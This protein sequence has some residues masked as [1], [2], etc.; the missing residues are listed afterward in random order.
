[1]KA[2]A[3]QSKSSWTTSSRL[4]RSRTDT[5]SFSPPKQEDLES[6]SQQETATTPERPWGS[7]MGN[8]T[9]NPKQKPQVQAF[10]GEAI[11]PQWVSGARVGNFPHGNRIARE[12]QGTVNPHAIPSVVVPNLPDRGVCVDGKIGLRPDAPVEVARHEV[13]HSLGANEAIAHR[14]ERD[15]SVLSGLQDSISHNSA[16]PVDGWAIGFEFQTAGKENPKTFERPVQKTYNYPP[17][18]MS[19][20][21]IQDFKKHN[22]PEITTGSWG[23]TPTFQTFKFDGF[24]IKSD[25]GD[26]E[27]ETDAV[28]ESK[29]GRQELAGIMDRIDS[30][31]QTIA[32]QGYNEGYTYKKNGNDPPTQVAL[33]DSRK[34]KYGIAHGNQEFAGKIQATL[35][36]KMERISDL[37]DTVIERRQD[38]GYDDYHAAKDKTNSKNIKHKGREAIISLN[39]RTSGLKENYQGSAKVFSLLHLLASYFVYGNAMLKPTKYLKN[40]GHTVM[41]RNNIGEIY[42]HLFSKEEQQEMKSLLEQKEGQQMIAEMFGVSSFQELLTKQLL[43]KG[44]CDNYTKDQKITH[45]PGLTM[46]YIFE[47]MQ[48][49]KDA[50]DEKNPNKSSS[51]GTIRKDHL[52]GGQKKKKDPFYIGERDFD[53]KSND[54][55]EEIDEKG[56]GGNIRRGILVELRA[57]RDREKYTNWKN[58]VMMLFDLTVGLNDPEQLD[59]SIKRVQT[60]QNKSV[61]KKPK[62]SQ[63]SKSSHLKQ[64]SNSPQS[65]SNSQQQLQLPPPSLRV[66]QFINFTDTN[67]NLKQRAKVISIAVGNRGQCKVKLNNSFYNLRWDGGKWVERKN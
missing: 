35:G 11:S 44:I 28:P 54:N 38:F 42:Q 45:L 51:L 61:K 9:R 16:A 49:G 33:P 5:E 21:E 65:Q 62:K 67:D 3:P 66:N 56:N 15:P 57:M 34:L 50:I 39:K 19:I 46:G 17:G 29:E 55:D 60:K 59:E 53:E 52:F 14:A 20:R 13:A 1:M 36:V 40:V 31:M 12:T 30:K 23:L 58:I 48:K 18:R 43:P 63:K 7:T 6:N 25:D 26:M 24:V 64:Q 22:E 27:V 32:S 37:I 4:A 8:V 41:G 10:S 47:Q 2:Y